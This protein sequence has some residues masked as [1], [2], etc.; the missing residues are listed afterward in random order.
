MIVISP[1]QVPE[2]LR[3]W[4]WDVDGMLSCMAGRDLCEA[5]RFGLLA[6]DLQCKLA[7][8][9]Q[10]IDVLEAGPAPGQRNKGTKRSR[11]MEVYFA[12]SYRYAEEFDRAADA[13]AERGCTT[14]RWWREHAE[15]TRVD[16]DGRRLPSRDPMAA[17][18]HALDC[19]Q[20]IVRSDL[21]IV[22]QPSGAATHVEMGIA[23]GLL[24]PV[25]MVGDPERDECFYHVCRL[26]VTTLDE[27]VQQF[28][29]WAQVA[30]P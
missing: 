22:M 25:W 8:L 24:K 20:A 9:D 14:F 4:A 12:G 16:D 26:S 19:R 15:E 30:A 10:M 6:H 13:L 3:E 28:S 21:V 18:T 29:G 7:A 5:G 17:G 2:A 11:D 23:I 27:A 1:E